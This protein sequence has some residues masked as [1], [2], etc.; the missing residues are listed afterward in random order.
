[1][2]CGPPKTLF[3]NGAN[4]L[5]KMVNFFFLFKKAQNWENFVW[6]G[7]YDFVQILPACGTNTY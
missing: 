6:F 3:Q 1:M 4:A 2:T 7:P 5:L